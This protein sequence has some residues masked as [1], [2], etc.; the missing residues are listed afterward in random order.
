MDKLAG[1]LSELLPQAALHRYQKPNVLP[2]TDEQF[3]AI[4]E[5]CDAVIAVWGH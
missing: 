3:T 5:D 4:T 1:V 2:I